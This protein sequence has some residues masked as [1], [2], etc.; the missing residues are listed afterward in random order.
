[1]A[2]L[3]EKPEGYHQEFWDLAA[4]VD[5]NGP[6]R[7]G[8]WCAKVEATDPGKSLWAVEQ[9]YAFWAWAQEHRCFPP[10]DGSPEN[11]TTF[12]N[13]AMFALQAIFDGDQHMLADG[14]IFKQEEDKLNATSF[15]SSQHGVILRASSGFTNHLYLS[16]VGEVNVGVVAINESHGAVT[17]SLAENIEGVSCREI[18]QSLWGEEA[19]GARQHR[20]EPQRLGQEL[21]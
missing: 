7:I 20:R 18:V 5:I 10:R 11:I 15:I 9:L 8:E 17:V 3:D 1:M 6:H 2:L 21:R 16:P 12:V 14:R 19:G 4:H 13:Q